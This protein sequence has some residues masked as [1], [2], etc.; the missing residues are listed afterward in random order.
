MICNLDPNLKIFLQQFTVPLFETEWQNLD[1]YGIKPVTRADF[2]SV[3]TDIQSILV[4]ATRREFTQSASISDVELD[5]AVPINTGQ[6]VMEGLEQ[7]R[8]PV[9]YRGTSCES[10]DR[11]YYRDTSDRQSSVLGSCKLCPCQ[12]AESCELGSDRRV[13]CNCMPGYFGE[14][15]ES[16]G[17]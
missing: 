10:C 4:R 5:T 15:C 9:G 1:R 11:N 7:C 2:L 17:E 3:L 6:G 13:K 12:H 16:T 14:R 8:C